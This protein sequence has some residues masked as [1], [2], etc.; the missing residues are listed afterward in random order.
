MIRRLRK[1]NNRTESIAVTL[2]KYLVEE[3]ELFNGKEVDI[4]AK[5]RK[6]IIDLDVNYKTTNEN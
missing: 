5:G 3:F 6:I 1:V 2:P 4:F